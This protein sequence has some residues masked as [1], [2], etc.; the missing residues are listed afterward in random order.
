MSV[1][2]RSIGSRN[3]RGSA[4]G[5]RHVRALAAAFAEAGNS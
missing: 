4:T 2:G 5:L 1:A 3:A